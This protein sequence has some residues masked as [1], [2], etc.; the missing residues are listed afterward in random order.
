MTEFLQLQRI[1]KRFGDT[2]A[3]DALDLNVPK[4]CIYGM[5]GPNG[6]GKTTT[7]RMIMNI[8]APDSGEVLLNG[9]PTDPGF[10]NIVGYLPEERGLYKNMTLREVV[11]YMGQLKL[12]SKKDIESRIDPWLERMNLIDY[13]SQKVEA[14]SKG[15]QQKLQ[16]ITT[17]IHNP[18]VII[19]DELFSGLD[20]LN[21][22]LIK[23]V[24]LDLK[25]EGCTILFSTHVM[26]QA[27]K[28]CDYICM[29]NR[30]RKVL[31]GSLIDVKSDYGKN[32]VRLEIDGDGSFL[33]S[34][35]GVDS[36]NNFTNYF[37][38]SLSDM[39]RS[40]D[41]LAAISERVTITRFERI[42]P[43]LYNIFIQVAGAA[44]T[45]TG[46]EGAA[47]A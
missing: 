24:I 26:E 20:P 33:E 18:E 13:K 36:V 41:I 35:P 21:I 32:S 8:I 23:N 1:T 5:I 45:E 7:I 40:N 30:G 47:D 22:E 44:D 15:M 25:R 17:L 16:F 28:L 14:L 42:T 3:V 38:L 9:K 6:A 34:I 37:E 10:K 4:G 19:L 46:E 31:D 2:L 12:A 27:E 43:S 11:V 29:I 39:A